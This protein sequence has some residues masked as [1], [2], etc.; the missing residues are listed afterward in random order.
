[1]NELGIGMPRWK[2][3][4]AKCRFYFRCNRGQDGDNALASVKNYFDGF[5]DAGLWVND[6]FVKHLETEIM[7]DKANPRVEIEV[8]EML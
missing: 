6:K 8:L 7:F 1:M 5:T 3:A 4:T 2:H